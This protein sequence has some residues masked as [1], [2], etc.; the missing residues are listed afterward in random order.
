MI[1]TTRFR[2]LNSYGYTYR[3]RSASIND[4]RR[5]YP[6]WAQIPKTFQS[7]RMEDTREAFGKR[8]YIQTRITVPTFITRLPVY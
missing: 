2:T 1:F 7:A 5:V 6:V 3:I 8:P 4:F